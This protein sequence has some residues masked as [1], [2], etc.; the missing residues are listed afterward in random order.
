[1]GGW[2]RVGAVTVATRPESFV[3][4]CTSRRRPGAFSTF[5]SFAAE[6]AS[7]PQS[8]YGEIES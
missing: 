6:K 2:G 8:W 5:P 4:I 3:S 7:G 1:M